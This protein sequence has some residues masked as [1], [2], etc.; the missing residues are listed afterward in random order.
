MYSAVDLC[1]LRRH[2]VITF[3]HSSGGTA[4]VTLNRVELM[5]FVMKSNAFSVRSELKF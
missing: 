2:V 3:I 4:N 1:L 5:G